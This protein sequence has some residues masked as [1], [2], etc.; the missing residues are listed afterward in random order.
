MVAVQALSNFPFSG[1]AGIK[2][3]T[4]NS[5]RSHRL[6][7]RATN[8][9]R[10]QKSSGR[11]SPVLS[12]SRREVLLNSASVFTLGALLNI[13]EAPRPKTIG[14]QDIYGTKSLS[15]CPP[16]PNCI[17]TAEEAND[18]NHFVPQ[19]TYNPEDGRGRKNPATQAQAMAEL[20]EVVENI[21][22]DKFQP[23]IVKQTDNYLYVEFV[24]PLLGFVDDVEFFFPG[25]KRDLVEYRS[26]SRVG[27]SD[28]DINRKRIRAIRQELEKKGWKSVG[29]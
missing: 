14:I 7:V 5:V 26:A 27:E 25:G 21:R 24:S 4:A 22:P 17:S 3:V 16:T 6:S 12:N 20:R 18:P 1:A 23:R 2:R 13:G 11:D 19:W 29:Y 28:F 10:N 15:L 9:D 8:S